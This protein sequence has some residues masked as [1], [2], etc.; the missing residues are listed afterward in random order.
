MV[1]KRIKKLFPRRRSSNKN[2]SGEQQDGNSSSAAD[3]RRRSSAASGTSA[4]AR[5]LLASADSQSRTTSGT[6]NANGRGSGTL[7]V[8]GSERRPTNK[9]SLNESESTGSGF[10]ISGQQ[11]EAPPVVAEPPP[12]SSGGA[13]AGT[14]SDNINPKS[15][16]GRSPT[17]GTIQTSNTTKMTNGS[18][19]A[20]AAAP[21][22]EEAPAVAPAA[23]AAP[24]IKTSGYLPLSKSLSGSL[25][26]T[27]LSRKIGGQNRD[28]IFDDPV[29]VASYDSV[30]LLEI[31]KLPRGGISM[32]TQAVGRVQV[33]LVGCIVGGR[34]NVF[35]LTYLS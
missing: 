2:A 26:G 25:S 33:S 13:A 35:V 19:D 23:K 3:D 4:G 29:V 15:S 14:D 9:T 6:S 17:E 30:P 28:A 27:T 18:S 16:K 1:T 34:L 24:K 32:E 22:K 12:S 8:E 20:Q 10:G 31:T 5:E 7:S 11:G 21:P